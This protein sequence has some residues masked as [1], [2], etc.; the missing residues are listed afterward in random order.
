[1]AHKGLANIPTVFHASELN[2]P[3]VTGAVATAF[4]KVRVYFNQ[5][6]RKSDPG[7]TNDALNPA[8]YAFTGGLVASSVALIV[9]GPTVVEITI[10][11][12]MLQGGPYEV[13]VTNV[14]NMSS[15]VVDPLFDTATFSGIGVKPEVSGA[16][17][18]DEYT[19]RVTFNEAMK[20][21]AALVT[22]GNYNFT[23]G[24]VASAVI[25]IDATNVDVTV[26]EM[27][28]LWV[29]TVTVTNV[30]DLAG[31]PIAPAPDNQATFAG[32]GVAP[33]LLPAATPVPGDDQS[34]YVDY[35]ETV[36]VTQATDAANYAIFPSLGSLTI[37]QITA[38]RYKVTFTLSAMSATLYTITV[39]GVPDIVGNVIDPA[40]NE[41]AWTAVVPSPP[42]L[43]F[44][45]GDQASNVA[46]RDYLRVQAIDTIPTPSGIDVSTWDIWLNI[47]LADGSA[48]S[49]DVMRNGVAKPG[50]EVIFLGDADDPVDGIYARLRPI[51][52]YWP[53]EATVLVYA[54][55]SDN[56]AV[57]SSDQWTCYFGAFACFENAPPTLDALD[58]TLINGFSARF[59]ATDQ[60]RGVIM[61]ACTTSVV[62][63]VQARTLLWL[64]A[65]TDL[66]TILAKVFDLALVQDIKLCDRTSIE[67][68]H[69]ILLRNA[70][71]IQ[72]ARHEME[73]LVGRRTLD[74]ILK[75]L[76]SHSPL[77]VVSAACALVVM[78]AT[79]GDS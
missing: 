56:D 35:T 45:P 2:P 37:T 51:S 4:D 61:R 47:T 50:Y 57:S 60:L 39:T 62:R 10:T 23:G 28:I 69:G 40:H 26:N 15:Q 68:V 3:M 16:V 73:S 38:T 17:A 9:G 8:N 76:T 22:P 12:E 58:T 75:Y 63:Q 66:R 36:R 55:V 34:V 6:M 29:Y 43:D 18:Q 20:N 67:A 30:E 25:R 78:A 33:Q 48:F 44:H 71:A 19:V 27:H 53:E 72:K 59:P 65:A 70:P 42:F 31:N 13:E 32:I 79:A 5:E 46:P 21:N 14:Q 24:L 41:A 49:A 7:G 77:H 54:Q 1:M 74:P 11:G 64:A 52:G